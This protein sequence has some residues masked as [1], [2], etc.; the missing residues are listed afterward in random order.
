MSEFEFVA[1]ISRFEAGTTRY[2]GENALVL[3]DCARLVFENGGV[4]ESRLKSDWG[5]T[6]VRFFSGPSTQAFVAAKDDFIIL[7]F[8]GT[9][10]VADWFRNVDVD[11]VPGPVGRV[12]HGF[13]KALD[14]VWEGDA[15][16]ETAVEDLR[17]SE[18]TVWLAGHSLGGAL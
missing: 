17:N 12:H 8:R 11:L 18:Q 6:Q 4:V 2:R 3:F 7:S 10:D 16:M 1:D 5:F 14:E 15:G 9:E 13:Q